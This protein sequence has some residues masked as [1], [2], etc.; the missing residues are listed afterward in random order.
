MN[1]SKAKHYVDQQ[2]SAIRT[3][4]KQLKNQV[5]ILKDRN[6]MMRDDLEKAKQELSLLRPTKGDKSTKT[7]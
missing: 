3:E 5:K 7:K 2:L 4:N 1:E 6:K